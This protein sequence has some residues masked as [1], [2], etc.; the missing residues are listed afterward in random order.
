MKRKVKLAWL[1]CFYVP[2]ELRQNETEFPRKTDT[3]LVSLVQENNTNGLR[4]LFTL[5]C[6]EY[7]LLLT[8]IL[9]E[10]FYFHNVKH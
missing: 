9:G 3:E 6:F 1:V 7:L 4:I 10:K 8:F 5:I 2:L